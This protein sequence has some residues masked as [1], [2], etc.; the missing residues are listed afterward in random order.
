MNFKRFTS[1]HVLKRKTAGGRVKRQGKQI[2]EPQKPPPRPL[3]FAGADFVRA[4]SSSPGSAPA[5]PAVRRALLSGP[6]PRCPGPCGGPGGRAPEREP[7]PEQ[8]SRRPRTAPARSPAPT[9]L[10]GLRPSSVGLPGPSR[11]TG[12]ASHALGFHSSHSSAESGFFWFC[13]IF[14]FQRPELCPAPARLLPGT[15]E[16]RG[17]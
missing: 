14:R 12:S 9:R 1:P 5:G 17:S 13:F 7:P 4:E 8:Q 6:P 16:E 15:C 3:P 11:Q 10:P 2:Y